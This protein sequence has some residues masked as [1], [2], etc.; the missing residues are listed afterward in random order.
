MQKLL[1]LLALCLCGISHGQM[2]E[3]IYYQFNRS[4]NTVENHALNPVGNNPAS[5]QGSLT[6]NQGGFLSSRALKGNGSKAAFNNIQ[7]GWNT[8]ING[9]FTLAFWTKDIPVSTRLNYV[10]GDGQA[11]EFRCF[12]NGVAGIGNWLVRG[13]QLPD[14]LV[15]GAATMSARMVHIVYDSAA[16]TYT[17]YVD[18]VQNTQVTVDSVPNVNGSGL[19]IG[20]YL[21]NYGLSG[22]LDEI[23][24]YSRA[25]S[26]TEIA[27]TWD[28]DLNILGNC[29]PFANF[30]TDTIL[31]NSALLSWIPG[32]G[33]AGYYLEYGP[34]GFLPGQGIKVFGSYP[35]AGSNYLIGGLQPKTDYDVYF[36]EYCGSGDS[37]YLPNPLSFTTTRLCPTPTQFQ[38]F[39]PGIN[40]IPISW[41]NSGATIS[42]SVIYGFAGFDPALG[43]LT[44]SST[45]NSYLITGLSPATTYDIYL[46]ANCGSGQGGSDTLGPLHVTTQCA[47]VTAFPYRQGFEPG[48]PNLPG[49]VPQCWL[50]SSA[51]DLSWYI[52]K[53]GTPSSGTGPA[54]DKTTD[55]LTGHYMYLETSSSGPASY[56]ST[57]EFDITQLSTPVFSFWYHM[58][59]NSMGSLQ[60]QVSVNAGQSWLTIAD[61][62]GEQHWGNLDAW[63][64]MV[65]DISP[66]ISGTTSFRFVGNRGGSFTGDLAI[67]EVVVENGPACLAPSA[68][69]VSATDSSADFRLIGGANSYGVEWGDAGFV[70]GTGCNSAVNN[71]IFTLHNGL[72]SICIPVF[73]GNK[74]IDVYV[75][76]ECDATNKIKI[77]FRTDC[78]GYYAPYSNNFDGGTLMQNPNCWSSVVS[79]NSQ[80]GGAADI[81]NYG[82]PLSLPYHARIYNG[83]GQGPSDTSLLISPQFLDLPIGNKQ[84]RFNAKGN[85][86]GMNLMVGTWNMSAGVFSL[87]DTITLTDQYLEYVISMGPLGTYNGVDERLALMHAQGQSFSTVFIDDFHYEVE[88]IC[89]PP[90]KSD[91]VVTDLSFNSAIVE[92][93]STGQGK[94]T[95]LEWALPGFSAGNGQALGSSTIN[96]QTSVHRIT[97]LL[98]NTTYEVY[99]QDSCDFDQ[100]SPWIGPLTFTTSCN[101]T[102]AP[103]LESFDGSTWQSGISSS[104]G[105]AIGTCWSREPSADGDYKWGVFNSYTPSIN[106]GPSKDH[107]GTGNF[108]YTE[109]S[110]GNANDTA[111]LYSPWVDIS[112]LNRPSLEFYFHRYG[113]DLPDV[114]VEVRDQSSTWNSLYTLNT[115]THLSETDGFQAAFSRL[116][117]LGDTVQ[118]RFT[119]ISAGCCAGDMALDD[120]RFDE[121]PSCPTITGLQATGTSDTSA[122]VNWDSTAGA[123]NYQVWI[124]QPGSFNNGAP[125]QGSRL[126]SNRASLVFDTLNVS[127]CYEV[128]VRS[129]CAAGDTSAWANPVVFCSLCPAILAPILQSFDLIPVA[130]A[131]N[132]GDCWTTSNPDVLSYGWQVNQGP[133]TSGNTGPLGDAGTGSG[134]YIYT[135]ASVGDDGDEAILNSARLDLSA[136]SSPQL[137][138]SYH[139]Y[140]SDIDTIHVDVI[141]N[142]GLQKNVMSLNGPQQFFNTDPWLDTLLD[143][144]SYVGPVQIRFR[145]YRGIGF[146]GDMALDN[147]VVADPITCPAPTGLDTTLVTSN[148]AILLWQG[149]SA[150]T[151]QVAHGKAVASISGANF[152]VVNT[153]RLVLS[154]LDGG[155]QYGFFV[156]KICGV[157]DSSQWAGPFYFYTDCVPL[158]N[159]PY[160]ANFEGV[161]GG[162]TAPFVN[163]WDVY[164]PQALRW[165]SEIASGMDDNTV[166]TGP[167]FDNTVYPAPMGTYMFLE[168]SLNGSYAELISPAINVSGLQNPELVYHFHMYGQDINK[169]EVYLE[170]HA[171]GSRFLIDSVVGQK[172]VVGSMP[173]W[174]HRVDL[175]NIPLSTYKVVFK[176][177]KGASYKGDIAIDDMWID[178]SGA[179]A[180]IDPQALAV[181][182]IGCDSVGL[183]WL[184]TSGYSVVEYGLRGFASG[185]GIASAAANNQVVLNGLSPATEYD[186]RVANIC[187][188]D[189]SDYIRVNRITT[190]SAPQPVAV[191][192]YSDSIFASK[193]HSAKYFTFNA[194]QSVNAKSYFWD[195]GNGQ[196]STMEEVMT[197]FVFNQTYDV[198]LVAIN[199]CGSDTTWLKVNVDIDVDETPLGRSL[200]LYPNPATGAVN[201]E[202]NTVKDGNATIR[203]SDVTGKEVFTKLEN[204]I[205]GRYTRQYDVSKLPAGIYLLEIDDGEYTTSRKLIKTY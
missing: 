92:W 119:A 116:V 41:A 197:F 15:S 4:G 46:S 104:E 77:S 42:H 177:Y 160:Y 91:F 182:G 83:A 196:T 14:L 10:F 39:G 202:F 59:G 166:S 28:K 170:S 94:Q 126:I 30:T 136:L 124:G 45:A 150:G 3:L 69:F 193:N 33:N 114:R 70:P 163:C 191:I 24:W 65:I 147:M 36:G 68:F 64:Q 137:R 47:P 168:A 175:S 125:G 154:G 144:S 52:N 85:L 67:D 179:N 34:S 204:N 2:P 84:I 95:L 148:S 43:G 1:V 98:P 16:A 106:T 73:D 171:N 113:N 108:I 146:R 189:T 32:P 50:V 135:E 90:L 89:L 139:M 29:P 97:G 153:N 187:G 75:W 183:S 162:A 78:S 12:T 99:L 56:L 141:D 122:V 17:S 22:L 21:D 63:K 13:G 169:L 133:T 61:L 102:Q 120:V 130:T 158:V 88:P 23:R 71:G 76:N 111:W 140:G 180:C 80:G 55:T 192:N 200:S 164:S 60:L 132:L 118:V 81:Y 79:G 5:I 165:E 74:L 86:S 66:F 151:Y 203:L 198:M 112:A 54:V 8:R 58:F 37:A 109:A 190:L 96:G 35:I 18:G 199:G 127:A 194:S 105:D 185:S 157:G 123:Q 156:R 172:Q 176:G 31:A 174:E 103:Y 121:A 11:D 62:Q 19:V 38:A 167:H 149:G 44:S 134:K 159:A 7:T 49:S 20:G 107:S 110:S 6:I 93:G 181:N 53:G 87:V 143:L 155:S 188:T 138:F 205:N 72:D 142:N 186:V 40:S 26:V 48:L 161:G 9:S 117:G 57:P 131:G 145:T 152:N 115:E 128:S 82:S 201:I 101:P 173:F 27:S 100:F 25:L 184:S 51:G 195:F 178:N 129:I